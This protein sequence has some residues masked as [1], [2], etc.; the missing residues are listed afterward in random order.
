MSQT[1]RLFFISEWTLSFSQSFFSEFP[2][3][4]LQA[5]QWLCSVM[6]TDLGLVLLFKSSHSLSPLVT[7]S[8]CSNVDESVSV[9]FTCESVTQ[10]FETL[11]TVTRQAP[12]SM[13][14]PRQE[15]NSGLRF[16]FQGIFQTQRLNLGLLHCRQILYC[17]SHQGSQGVNIID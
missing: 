4:K 16:L 10:S 9:L 12:L 17:L 3:S 14:F 7:T 8:V 11:W 15:Y 13:A 2:K 6:V 5:F 1:F